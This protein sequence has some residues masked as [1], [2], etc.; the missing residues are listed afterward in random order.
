MTAFVHFLDLTQVVE[1]S[2]LCDGPQLNEHN[3]KEVFAKSTEQCLT[4]SPNYR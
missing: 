3:F 2:A 1:Q 4:L